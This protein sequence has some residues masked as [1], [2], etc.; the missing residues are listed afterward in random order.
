MTKAGYAA[1]TFLAL[2]GLSHGA[3]R[4]F[5]DGAPWALD[6]ERGCASCHLV[7]EVARPGLAD[8]L[9]VTLA[10]PREDQ[11]LEIAIDA[12]ALG[13]AVTGFLLSMEGA[14]DLMSDV[15][16]IA[17]MGDKIRSTVPR[18][19][20]RWTLRVDML[21]QDMCAHMDSLPVI[22]WLNAADGDGSPFGDH[23]AKA[24]GMIAITNARQASDKRDKGCEE[25]E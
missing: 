4:A 5:P 3:A 6:P 8:I 20:G 14:G 2:I 13:G 23:I 16:G 10:A 24:Q 11:A 18:A 25:K 21:A 19:D 12:S 17:V 22:L 15:E 1:L 9:G 7:R